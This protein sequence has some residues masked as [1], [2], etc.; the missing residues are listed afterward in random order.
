[1]Y[2]CVC[3][4]IKKISLWNLAP[5]VSFQAEV[6]HTYGLNVRVVDPARVGL[7][8]GETINKED[9]YKLLTAF[10]VAD[11]EDKLLAGIF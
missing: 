1:M 6:A 4:W 5:A 2:V 10:G 3:M 9:V 11:V 8:F 7:S